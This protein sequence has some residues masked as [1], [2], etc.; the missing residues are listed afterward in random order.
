MGAF[1]MDIHKKEYSSGCNRTLSSAIIFSG[2]REAARA[3][4]QGPVGAA[5]RRPVR[6]S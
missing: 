5:S 6:E 4:G 1:C 3:E 2:P